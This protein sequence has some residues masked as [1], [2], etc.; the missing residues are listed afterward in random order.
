MILSFV[1]SASEG[2]WAASLLGITT[3]ISIVVGTLAA[4]S[5]ALSLTATQALETP[6]PRRFMPSR[7]G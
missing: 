3:A 5:K 4:D 2:D 1:V 6:L 7:P